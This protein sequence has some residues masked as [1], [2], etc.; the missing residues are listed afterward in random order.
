MDSVGGDTHHTHPLLA[1]GV[2]GE[3]LDVGRRDAQLIGQEF[4]QRTIGFAPHR[5]GRQP[6]LERV[7]VRPRHLVPP[8]AGQNAH[9]EDASPFSFAYLQ[10]H[11]SPRR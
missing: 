1:R 2:T 4:P 8:A 11:S 5:W 7:S 6:Y 3:N 10:R 9:P